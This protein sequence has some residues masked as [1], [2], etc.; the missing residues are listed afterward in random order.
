MVAMQ[1]SAGRI[2]LPVTLATLA[3]VIGFGVLSASEFV[4]TA[5]FGFLIAVTLSLGTLANLTLLPALLR[6]VDRD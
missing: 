4:P 1:L 6:F 5:T 3:L 2:G